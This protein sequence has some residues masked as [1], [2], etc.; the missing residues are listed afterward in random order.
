MYS[1][2]TVF[3]LKSFMQKYNLQFAEANTPEER[4]LYLDL[5]T[6][7]KEQ[8]DKFQNVGAVAPEQ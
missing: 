5:Y 1:G 3:D 4:V 2:T 6:R 7:L 8:A